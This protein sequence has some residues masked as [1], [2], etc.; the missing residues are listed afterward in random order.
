M[1]RFAHV[2][3]QNEDD[4]SRSLWLDRLAEVIG[5]SRPSPDTGIVEHALLAETPAAQDESLRQIQA[6]PSAT[7]DLKARALALGE[8]LDA[9]MQAQAEAAARL[10]A[11]CAGL[12]ER[13]TLQEQALR[14]LEIEVRHR[15]G[16]LWRLIGVSRKPGR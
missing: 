8:Q 15:G 11:L 1:F 14:S 16:L 5:S 13:L 6:G 10:N 4:E 9:S 7:D 12:E 2:P 3:K